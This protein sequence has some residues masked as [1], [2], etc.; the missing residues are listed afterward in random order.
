MPS[1]RIALVLASLSLGAAP[2]RAKTSAQRQADVERGPAYGDAELAPYFASGPLK[3]AF[4]EFQAGRAGQALKL[5]PNRPRASA[6]LWLRAQALRATG[7]AAAAREAFEKLAAQ[8]GPLADRALHL[9]GLSAVDAGDA[10]AAD[11][12]L[13]QVPARYVDAD[14]ALLERARQIQFLRISGPRTASD[15][16]GVLEPIFSGR[17][18]ADVA[19]AHLVGGD[20]QLAAGEKDKAR[21]HWRAAW[22]DHPLSP[23][24]DSA[25]ERERQLGPGDPIP[26]ARLVRR[27]EILL[28]AHRNR[29]ALEQ[30][31]RLELPSLCLGGC[32]ED[33]TAAS[34]IKAALSLLAPGGMPVEHQ[35][36]AEEIARP[37]EDPADPLACRARVYQGRAWRKEHEYGK[38]RSA[39]APVVLRCADPDLRARALYL[40]AQL[41]TMAGK[42]EAATLWEALHRNFPG[43]SLADD[44]VFSQAVARRRAGNFADERAFLQDIVDHHPESDLRTEAQFRL[45][46]SHLAEGHP[47]EGLVYLDELAARPDPDGAE[48][49]RAKYWR[50]RALLDPAPGE[51]EAARAAAR[52]AARADLMWLAELRPLTYHGLLA[53]GRLAEIDPDRLRAL[54]QRETKRVTALL[55]SRGPLRAGPLVRDPHL[56]AAVE[57]LRLG[58]NAEAAQELLAVDRAPARALGQ[59]GEEPMVLLADLSARAGD[60]RN[61]HALI[62]IDLRTLLRRTSE[63][64]ALRAAALAYPLAFRDQIAKAAHGVSVPVDLLQALMREESALD[65]KALSPTGALGLTQLMPATARSVAQRLKLRD[66]STPRLVEP[67]LNIRIG[68]AYLGELYARFRHPALALASYNAGPGTVAGWMK[69]RGAL[70]L[71]EFVEEIP[72]DETRGYVKRCLRSFAAYQYLYGSGRSR[73]PQLGQELASPQRPRQGIRPSRSPRRGA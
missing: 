34:L 35:P 22:L 17:V 15:V 60:L 27:A 46:W 9:A 23:A 69:A 16:E 6:E 7:K 45:F 40:L 13:A 14:Q 53:R 29:D 24:A 43:S 70:P 63:P 39:L 56:L 20:A 51:S 42:P 71:D 28:E 38:A 68:A 25:R 73:A 65:P 31:G 19:A 21:E 62:R 50:A 37:P 66:Y 67:D 41:D 12:L 55:R 49:E 18:R 52:E 57:L 44:A 58:M 59:Q 5:L 32:P 1:F 26:P 4:A 47:R 3:E 10:A 36:T 48:E 54:E 72:F 33:G 30:L 64:L 61:A 8:G 2:L 11:R